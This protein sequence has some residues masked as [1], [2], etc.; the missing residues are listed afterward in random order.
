MRDKANISHQRQEG[1]SWVI[2]GE[3]IRRG[4]VGLCPLNH[5][6]QPVPIWRTHTTITTAT[7]FK[8]WVGWVIR[9]GEGREGEQ[10][11]RGLFECGKGPAPC[12]RQNAHHPTHPPPHPSTPRHDNGALTGTGGGDGTHLGRE[13]SRDNDDGSGEWWTTGGV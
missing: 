10:I 6:Q 9:K 4:C 12:L 11:V 8:L 3:G 5:H 1:D 13:G 2:E 7:T